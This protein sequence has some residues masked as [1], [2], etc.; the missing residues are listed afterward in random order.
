MA[1]WPFW[2]PSSNKLAILLFHVL[3]YLGLC[4]FVE[5]KFFLFFFFFF[6]FVRLKFIN[7]EP[8]YEMISL[9]GSKGNL[10]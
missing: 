3:F 6:F 7:Y 5:N 8:F 9:L 4:L 10:Q 1:F 2:Q